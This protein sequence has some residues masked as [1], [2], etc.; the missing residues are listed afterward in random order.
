MLPWLL[1]PIF[2][3]ITIILGVMLKNAR[4]AL[5]QER[6]MR[7]AERTKHTSQLDTLKQEHDSANDRQRREFAQLKERAHLPLAQDLFEG[8]DVLD[9]AIQNARDHANLST[10]DLIDGVAMAQNS[11][12]KALAKHDVTPIDPQAAQA[13]F[14]PKYHEAISVRE[15]PELPPNTVASVMRK[16]WTHPSK[17]LRPAMVQT[18]KLPAIQAPPHDDEPVELDFSSPAE[19]ND[20]GEDLQRLDVT[21]PHNATAKK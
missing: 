1:L 9:M 12:H 11:L 3:L 6:A 19:L 2:L 21:E 4:A 16:G 18:S 15:D 14:D 17:V 10:R 7:A 20:Q 5:E 13:S 8:L